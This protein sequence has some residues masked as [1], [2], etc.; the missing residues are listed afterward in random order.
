MIINKFE[1]IWINKCKYTNYTSI[2]LWKNF[3]LANRINSNTIEVFDTKNGHYLF[4]ILDE[5]FGIFEIKNADDVYIINDILF[6]IDNFLGVCQ[7]Y[8]LNSNNIIG[9]FV[10]KDLKLLK[11]ICE[12]FNN[13]YVLFVL[14]VNNNILKYEIEINENKIKNIKKRHLL[15]LPKINFFSI[16]VDLKYNRILLNDKKN[17]KL[18]I[19]DLK[20]NIKNIINVEISN[21]IIYKNY[22]IYTDLENDTNMIHL[23]SRENLKYKMSYMSEKIKNITNIE[24]IND[25]IY[26]LDNHCTLSK[27]YLKNNSNNFLLITLGIIISSI[28]LK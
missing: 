8:N 14:D 19:L 12:Y 18:N 15:N 2:S 26:I 9:V 13:K 7:V 5:D 4:D 24:C 21:L 23:I 6:R 20:G 10:F 25:D 28:F 22:Y 16:L 1:I 11:S 27:I 3:I 17:S